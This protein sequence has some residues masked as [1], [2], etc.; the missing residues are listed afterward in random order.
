MYNMNDMDIAKL[1]KNITGLFY[2]LVDNK[3]AK[4]SSLPLFNDSGV[5]AKIILEKNTIEQAI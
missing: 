4:R 2:E 1:N 3:N 5:V